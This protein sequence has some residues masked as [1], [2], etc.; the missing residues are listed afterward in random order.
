MSL[1]YLFRHLPNYLQPRTDTGWRNNAKKYNKP[2]QMQ[3]TKFT[4][5]QNNN[6]SEHENNIIQNKLKQLKSK[7]S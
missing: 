3:I 4:T 6:A 2:K 1:T 5:M 7:V